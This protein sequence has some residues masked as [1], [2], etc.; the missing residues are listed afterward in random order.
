MYIRFVIGVVEPDSDA[1]TGIFETLTGLLDHED[2]PAHTRDELHGVRHWFRR[3]L[4]A[5]RELNR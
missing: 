2:T 3:N 5:P 4:K 1:E